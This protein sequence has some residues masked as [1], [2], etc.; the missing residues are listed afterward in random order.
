[1]QVSAVRQP[2]YFPAFR[3]LAA[4]CEDTCCTGWS[5]PVDRATYERFAASE[6]GPLR[7]AAVELIA[8][9][10]EG[11]PADYYA[12]IQMRDGQCPFL[13]QKLCSLQ[14]RLGDE[15][16]PKVCATY[17]RTM[18]LVDGVLEQALQTSCPEA[19][20]M[21][22]LDSRALT[23]RDSELA[24]PIRL[25]GASYVD[26]SAITGGKPYEFFHATRAKCIALLQDRSRSIA[27]R[28][29]R[30][31]AL[32]EKLD[33]IVASGAKGDF[34]AALSGEIELAASPEQSAAFQLEVVLEIVVERLA[35]YTGQAFRDCYGQVMKGLAWTAE[36]SMEDLAARF[37]AAHGQFYQRFL[38]PREY[39][40]ENILVNYVHRTM[41][42]FGPQRSEKML[43]VVHAQGSMPDKFRLLAAYLA[44][45]QVLLTGAA[46]CH[47]EQFGD[48]HVVRVVYSFSRS[49]EHSTTFPQKV[50]EILSAHGLS[51]C[52][53]AAALLRMRQA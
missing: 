23:Y 21:V 12:S 5:V 3:C 15:F 4:E 19:A 46:A 43:D 39:M 47:R 36:D 16:L 18:N 33:A 8:I 29:A 52:A 9:S 34:A 48:E 7:K 44:V 45:V 28:M 17:P 30:L 22:L 38:G 25:A 51:D 2:R 10:P 14:D 20:R 6:D 53:S 49:F 42:P 50:L 27:L 26:T 1:M 37:L 41:F 35:E 11:A 31:G 13:E 32:C 24:A 40:L